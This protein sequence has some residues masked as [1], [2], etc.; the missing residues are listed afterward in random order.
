LSEVENP[1]E[2]FLNW[3]ENLTFNEVS[4]NSHSFRDVEAKLSYDH[5]MRFVAG[6]SLREA[7]FQ[8]LSSNDYSNDF[9][10]K[11]DVE[12]GVLQR[13]LR[14][15]NLHDAKFEFIPKQS[16]AVIL[17]EGEAHRFTFNVANGPAFDLG[18]FSFTYETGLHE[19][20]FNSHDIKAE[21][22]KLAKQKNTNLI[23]G[24][25]EVSN[26]DSTPINFTDAFNAA[27]NLQ[28]FLTFAGGT[29][30]G[31][32]HAEGFNTSRRVCFA[33]GYNRRDPL[34]SHTNWFGISQ[35]RETEKVNGCFQ[36]ALKG[37]SSE[38]LKRCL[39]FYRA[40]TAV[41]SSSL[42]LAIV[43]S[44]AAL[45]VIVPYILSTRAKMDANLLGERIPFHSKV[46]ACFGV[47][48]LESDP[49]EMSQELQKKQASLNNVDAFE[50]SSMFRNR[51]VHQGKNFDV[52]GRELIEVWDLQMWMIEILIFF[53]IN[54]RGTMQ[55]R[56]PTTGWAGGATT[57]PLL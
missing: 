24:T 51:I 1:F 4:I 34:H 16:P 7:G 50:L 21:V 3:Q 15:T 30:P 57:I 33:P 35:I 19:I 40:S 43:S 45:E 10:K 6:F 27:C 56:R 13:S 44:S 2:D 41:R 8:L 42:E 37:E 9:F 32:G 11:G 18:A 49:L 28:R 5:D 47:V 39:E 46:R 23:T 17:R 26:V 52:N 20:T 31:I 38:I 36:T 22:R 48:G 54:Y 29:Q 25:I 14:L 12:F 55:D 53:L